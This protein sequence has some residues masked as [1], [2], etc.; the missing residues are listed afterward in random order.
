MEIQTN[1]E[2]DYLF[3]IIPK[4]HKLPMNSNDVFQYHNH[5]LQKQNTDNRKQHPII[6]LDKNILHH[7]YHSITKFELHL[8]NQ[9]TYFKILSYTYIRHI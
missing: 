2:T 8:S 4:L 3:L 1:S 6:K 9:S 7:K 5:I